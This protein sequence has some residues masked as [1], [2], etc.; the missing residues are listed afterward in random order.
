MRND[1]D[2]RP[3]VYE[4][5][6]SMMCKVSLLIQHPM[7]ILGLLPLLDYS[8]MPCPVLG[9]DFLCSQLM[10]IGRDFERDA[11]FRRAMRYP[12]CNIYGEKN[13]TRREEVEKY[14]WRRV[15]GDV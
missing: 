5:S 11:I 7:A 2:G 3:V 6:L 9:D 12:K 8:S 14:S 10:H 15:R 4:K 1:S 13:E